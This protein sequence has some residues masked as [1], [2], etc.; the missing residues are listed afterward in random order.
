MIK[1][2]IVHNLDNSNHGTFKALIGSFI[3][4]LAMYLYTK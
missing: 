3:Q 1:Q 4:I 2:I